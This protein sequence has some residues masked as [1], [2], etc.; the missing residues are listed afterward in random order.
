MGIESTKKVEFNNFLKWNLLDA[1]SYP[2]Y[3]EDVMILVHD[4]Q[5]YY[6]SIGFLF[7][8][9][10]SA[11]GVKFNF[12]KSMPERFFAPGEKV[13]HFAYLTFPDDLKKT[14]KLYQEALQ[15]GD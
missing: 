9:E 15:H 13:T 8:K 4:G 6:H 10:E 1:S 5:N 2:K 7:N 3:D 12:K 14:D 11:A